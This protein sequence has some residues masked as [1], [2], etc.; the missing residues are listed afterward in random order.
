[1]VVVGEIE[2]AVFG[3]LDFSS[4]KIISCG[5]GAVMD[6]NTQNLLT[7]HSTVIWLWN[8]LDISIRRIKKG[9]RPLFNVSDVEKKAKALFAERA[10]IYAQSADMMIINEHLGTRRVAKKIYEEV[11]H[12]SRNNVQNS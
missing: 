7:D 8:E 2:R 12:L 5:G 1:M 6:E 11:S 3:E 4:A 10:P 9:T